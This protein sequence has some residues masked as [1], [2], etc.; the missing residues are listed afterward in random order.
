MGNNRSKK[1]GIKSRT[2]WLARFLKS[3]KDVPVLAAVAAG[4]YPIFFYFTNNYTLIN[5]WRHVAYFAVAFVCVPVV[6]FFVAH[7]ISRLSVFEKI[8]KYVLPFLNIFV[9]LFLLKV[10]LY[11]GLQKK[12][13]VLILVVSA[14]F[15]FFLYKHLKKVI[16]I[17]LLLAA[18]GIYTL[19][20][21]VITQ[22]NYSD[23]WMKQPDNIEDA[24]FTKKPNV[25][26][27]QPDGYLNFSELNKGYYNYDNSKFESFL[28]E[29][30]F[31]NYPN[32]RSNYASTLASNSATFVMKHHYYNRGTSF[33]EAINARNVIVSSNPVLDLFKKNGYLTHLLVQKP[34]LLLNKPEIG[35]D[36][37]NFSLDDVAYIGTGLGPSQDLLPY[38]KQYM[39]ED[40][41]TPKFYFME[42]FNPGHIHNRKADS[43][44][45]D[46]ER[47][48]WIEGLEWANTVL[49]ETISHI[50]EEDPNALIIIM[51][52]HG[53]FVGLNYSKEI[54][55][56]TQ[57]RDII[58]SIFSS[59]LSI[60]WP[61]GEAPEVDKSI[62]T[63]INLFRVVFSYLCDDPSF[64]DHLQ[65][66][67][68]Y[69]IL[70]KDAPQGIYQYIDD[71]GKV[72]F[73]KR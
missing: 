66:D 12:L 56:K 6:V 8:K 38:L 70:N 60:H 61:E 23:E 22:L 28:A 4:L 62:S 68:S 33:S 53:G 3:D 47:E 40:P 49:T 55:Y 29:N 45:V 64:I 72:V 39:E 54:Y 25:Y 35:Y 13:I 20:P 10:C 16:V 15:A 1:T 2:G 69:V 42:I 43:R 36:K 21:T 51:A 9:F 32:F 41:D 58:Y 31:T 46:G 59:Q 17:Q 71:N 19:V 7:R 57:D 27:I 65:D 26:V 18:I 67:G 48:L 34:Y 14:I 37:S 24:V 63:A 73:K 30:N 11:A 50:K 52:D 44:G 5:T